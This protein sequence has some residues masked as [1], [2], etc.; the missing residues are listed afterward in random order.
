MSTRLPSLETRDK[1]I[2]TAILRSEIFLAAE[3]LVY[4]IDRPDER[5]ALGKLKRTV[6]AYWGRSTAQREAK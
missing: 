6:L 1:Q 2:H 3:Q 5:E 4:A